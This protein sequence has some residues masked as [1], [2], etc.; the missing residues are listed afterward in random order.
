MTVQ[1]IQVPKAIF[2]L[3]ILLESFEDGY[4]TTTPFEAK[5]ATGKVELVTVQFQTDTATDRGVCAKVRVESRPEL[6]AHVPFGTCVVIDSSWE[7]MMKEV[8]LWA[9]KV[10][11]QALAKTFNRDPVRVIQSLN[12]PEPR[13]AEFRGKIEIPAEIMATLA[14]E[15]GN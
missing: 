6:I 5:T 7:P 14:V 15:G 13:K 9:G 4:F 12:I 8:G 10:A 3:R 1:R 11:A 2:G